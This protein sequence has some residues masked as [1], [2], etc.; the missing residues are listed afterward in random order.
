M[1]RVY[2]HGVSRHAFG[3]CSSFSVWQQSGGAF[4]AGVPADFMVGGRD[5]TPPQKRNFF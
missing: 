1:H 2:M 5:D 3:L 4:T